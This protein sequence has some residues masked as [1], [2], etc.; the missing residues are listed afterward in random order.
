MSDEY[1]Q[2]PR[3]EPPPPIEIPFDRLSEDVLVGVIDN[4][5]SREGTDYGVHE[6]SYETKVAQVRRQ[7]EKGEVKIVYE[8]ASETVTLVT[9]QEWQRISKS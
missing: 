3:P 4:F 2:E 9:R 8:P 6:V 5:I 7:I 1:S